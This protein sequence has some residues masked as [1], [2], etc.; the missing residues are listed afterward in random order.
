MVAAVRDQP[1]RLE[2]KGGGVYG[3]LGRVILLPGL[4]F[5]WIIAMPRAEG[6]WWLPTGPA[7]LRRR[8]VDSFVRR[9][10]GT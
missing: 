4:I 2:G 10:D 6:R 5:A 7:S 3:E 8:T 9:G 1:G